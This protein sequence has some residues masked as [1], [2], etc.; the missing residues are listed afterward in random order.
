VAT[1]QHAFHGQAGALSYDLPVDGRGEAEGLAVRAE[2]ELERT[3]TVRLSVVQ[4][5]QRAH[6]LRIRMPE[7]ATAVRLS[8]DGRPLEAQVEGGYLTASRVWQSG[9]VVTVRYA[10]RT[11]EVKRGG[12]AG[13]DARQAAVFYGP[14]LLAVD[15]SASPNFFDEPA[16]ENQVQLVEQNGQLRLEAAPKLAEPAGR[17]AVPVA[18][19]ILHYRPGGYPMQP[20]TALLRPISEY[21]SGPDANELWFWLPLVPRAAGLDSNYK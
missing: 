12:N 2:S 1:F 20:Q 5:D 17:F 11:R 3:A 10:M 8:L 18:H 15:P 14:W 13:T 21:T 4:A 9:E 7:W 19:F 16:N 6:A